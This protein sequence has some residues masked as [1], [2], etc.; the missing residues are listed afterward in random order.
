[1]DDSLVKVLYGIGG[2]IGFWS[3][4]IV[5]ELVGIKNAIREN[6]PLRKE[7]KELKAESNI[8]RTE[9]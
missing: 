2:T 6:N 9:G 3:F 5:Y 4:M 7:H 1:M 8:T